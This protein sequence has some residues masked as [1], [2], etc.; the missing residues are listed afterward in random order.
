MTKH[1]FGI[2]NNESKKDS[3]TLLPNARK[4]L[5]RVKANIIKNDLETNLFNSNIKENKLS[6]REINKKV[7]KSSRLTSA[8][9]QTIKYNKKSFKRHFL[10][11][12]PKKLNF[13]L[14]SFS[15]VIAVF[16]LI[17]LFSEGNS[18]IRGKVVAY[19]DPSTFL[20][21]VKISIDQKDIFENNSNTGGFIIDDL[22]P[23]KHI[24]SFFRDSYQQVTKTLE[25]KAGETL[26]LTISMK[27]E[28]YSDTD[29]QVL[30]ASFSDNEISVINPLNGSI[31]NNISISG[32]GIYDMLF[33][34]EKH[35]LY[36]ANISDNSVSVIDTNNFK[37]IRKIKFP[38]SANPKKLAFSPDKEKLYVFNFGL[39]RINIIDTEDD[40][41]QYN[42]INLESSAI[43]FI[44][45]NN[46]ANIIVL[47]SKGIKT[48][49]DNGI[50]LKEYKFPGYSQREK[51]FK[52]PNENTVLIT[53]KT[54][55]SLIRFDLFSE[56]LNYI[57]L[58]NQPQEIEIKDDKIFVLYRDSFSI[59]SLISGQI[60]SG[61]FLT[62][63]L[64]SKDITVLP[65][66]EQIY[67][68]N[69]NNSQLAVFSPNGEKINEIRD[70]RQAK[71]LVLI[72]E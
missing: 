3:E 71:S 18:G 61:P 37:E 54:N 24:V 7:F 38:D 9:P 45:D 30:A 11:K 36:T 23:G 68:S 50:L 13:K 49:I 72:Q 16:I 26:N 70:V 35:K 39:K 25:L 46:T 19:N 43:D 31:T 67:I 29:F 6:G 21:G 2:N 63:D 34:A 32:K 12:K 44:V 55:K 58:E 42:E 41:A 47:D 33:L 40:S 59:H 64:N 1:I 69:Y 28:D 48:Y 65:D 15:G 51:I 53:D 17:L 57:N 20:S 27:L 5:N 62:N 66:D 8:L 56:S 52:I 14:I 22:K 10:K 4:E 60:I